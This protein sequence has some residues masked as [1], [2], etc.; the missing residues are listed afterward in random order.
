[1]KKNGWS[2]W[3]LEKK[4]SSLL[5]VL[6][7]AF[8]LLAFGTVLLVGLIAYFQSRA[9]LETAITERLESNANA[10][11]LYA[12]E[13]M[14]Q[15]KVELQTLAGIARI[16]SL[17]PVTV[18]EAIAQ[19]AEQWNWYETLFVAGSDG[20]TIVISSGDNI[21]ISDRSYFLAAM[22]KQTTISE[23]L[24]SRASGNVVFVVAAPVFSPTE[25]SKVVGVVAGTL[26]TSAFQAVLENAWLGKTG[27]AYLINKAG[28]MITPPRFSEEMK[29]AGLFKDR[30]ELEVKVQTVAAERL[31][32][33]QSGS[34]RYPDYRGVPVLGAYMPLENGWGLIV[35]QDVAEADEPVNQL[36]NI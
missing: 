19:Y 8:V 24:I 13:W 7:R 2:I 15:R 34:D 12:N 26:P 27:D 21:N 25:P 11:E 20:M 18:Q 31:L 9:A 28:Y 30:P 32:S 10:A 33:G 36:R 14:R 1:M 4:Q 22:Q 3:N 6:A 17:D 5:F 23:P 16:R 35:E 29:K